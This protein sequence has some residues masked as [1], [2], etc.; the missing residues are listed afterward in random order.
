MRFGVVEQALADG[1]VVSGQ[2]GCP[3]HRECGWHT[4]F[5]GTVGTG[6]FGAQ[7]VLLDAAERDRLTELIVDHVNTVHSGSWMANVQSPDVSVASPTPG[8][9]H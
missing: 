2:I 5:T 9:T 7:A 3:T 4:T 8:S 1:M 6:V